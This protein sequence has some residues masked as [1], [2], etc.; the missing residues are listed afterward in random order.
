MN[1]FKVGELL[2]KDEVMDIWQVNLSETNY[3]YYYH[4]SY[5]KK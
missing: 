1:E 5:L 2:T 4:L 3:V